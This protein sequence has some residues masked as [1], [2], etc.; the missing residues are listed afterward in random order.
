M[1]ILICILTKIKLFLLIIFLTCPIYCYCNNID[2]LVYKSAYENSEGVS[3]Y[4]I[5]KEDNRL[6]SIGNYLQKFDLQDSRIYLDKVINN[7]GTGRDGFVIGENLYVVV[8]SNG[9]GNKYT[10]VPDIM[11]D[12]EDNISNLAE[13]SGEFDSYSYEGT[14]YIDETGKPCPNLGF[15]SAKLSSS[16]CKMALLEKSIQ[17]TPEAY[18]SLWLN[19]EELKGKTIIPLLYNGEH[20]IVSM[21]AYYEN[22]SV[23]LGV[24]VKGESEYVEKTNIIINEWYNIKIHI[25]SNK[26]ELSY[27]SKECGNWFSLINQI[28]GMSNIQINKVCVGICSSEESLVYIDDYYYHPKELDVV[29]Y[30]NGTFSIYDKKNLE[31]KSQMHL[32]IR[33]NSISVHGKYLYL[34]CLRGINVYDI[35]DPNCPVLIG[36]HRRSKYTEFQGSDIFEKDNKVYL[37]VSLYTRGTAIFDVTNPKEIKLIKDIS[38]RNTNGWEKC[39]TFDVTC[40]YPYVYSTFTVNGSDMFT[41]KDHRG[42]LCIDVSNLN[43]VNQM[44]YEIPDETKSDITTAD[45]QPNQITMYH[46]KLI[47]NNSTKGM[48]IFDIAK[49][50][51]PIYNYCQ[52]LPGKSAV[53]AVSAFDDGSLFVGDT[54]S[55]SSEYPDYGIYWY[56]FISNVSSTIGDKGYT[57]FS[58]NYPLDLSLMIASKGTAKAYYASAKNSSSV[59]IKETTST[60]PAGEGLIL[61]GEA[62]AKVTIPVA[63]SGISIS[64]NLMIGCPTS[65]TITSETPGYD[66]FY[67]LVNNADEPEFQN[68]NNWVTNGHSI[69]IPAGK[70]YLNAPLF[71]SA[72]SLRA[73]FDGVTI[74]EN[75][76]AKSESSRKNGKYLENCRIVIYKN[77]MRF[78]AAGAKIR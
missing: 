20:D 40:R 1:K 13:N 70:A 39:F 38:F 32:E 34:C 29:S 74:V 15:K 47:L 58:S 66:N 25:N 37:V 17:S 64:D 18:I 35:S 21:I 51:K 63:K 60:V 36:T 24:K 59:T 14:S 27:R 10:K 7:H 67:V 46:D 11:F 31:L 26:I 73:I 71:N 54:K 23:Y 30:I 77:G 52:L 45:N 42:I 57:T 5:L 76:E 16:E 12:F 78:N 62:G 68:I 65:T 69:T 33:P 3:V 61:G 48:L 56:Q 6:Y 19:F 28:H 2:T 8:R 75:V 50:G 49:D 44:L 43:N 22:D 41:D 53:R 4:K 55:G 9:A 72:R